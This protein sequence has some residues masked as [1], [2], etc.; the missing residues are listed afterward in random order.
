MGDGDG[1]GL[2]LASGSPAG[3]FFDLVNY[4]GETDLDLMENADGQAHF[5][6]TSTAPL[7]WNWLIT[8]NSNNSVFATSVAFKAAP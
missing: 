3:A 8:S 4:A 7:T 2:G 5:Y 6:N 1:P